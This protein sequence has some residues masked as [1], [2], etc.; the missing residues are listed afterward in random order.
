MVT[1]ACVVESGTRAK[2]YPFIFSILLVSCRM[3][4]GRRSPSSVVLQVAAPQRATICKTSQLGD[5]NW[6][7][8]HIRGWWQ[9]NDCLLRSYGMTATRHLLSKLFVLVIGDSTNQG[10]YDEICRGVLSGYRFEF[11]PHLCAQQ[12]VFQRRNR[13]MATSAKEV[14][15]SLQN[16]SSCRHHTVLVINFGAHEAKSLRTLCPDVLMNTTFKSVRLKG[17][18]TLTVWRASRDFFKARN[19]SMNRYLEQKCDAISMATSYVKALE[20]WVQNV[21][22]FGFTGRIIWRTIQINFGFD[23]HGCENTFKLKVNELTR[24]NA[25]FEALDVEVLDVE[26]LTGLRPETFNHARTNHFYCQCSSGCQCK[27]DTSCEAYQDECALV[28][29]PRCQ[30]QECEPLRQSL[31]DNGEPNRVAAQLLLNALDTNISWDWGKYKKSKPCFLTHPSTMLSRNFKDV[32]EKYILSLGLGSRSMRHRPPG[33]GQITDL[34]VAFVDPKQHL[35]DLRSDDER[36]VPVLTF[37]TAVTDASSPCAPLDTCVRNDSVVPHFS[38]PYGSISEASKDSNK[39]LDTLQEI[40]PF[41]A[42]IVE[43]P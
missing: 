4:D 39:L 15:R 24:T 20:A 34:Y 6:T 35:E 2:F 21:R 17:E 43:I 42:S 26:V 32:G 12:F 13:L 8:D 11:V 28:A 25:I 10:I 38:I 16:R 18:R 5:G 9:P 33:T 41:C 37:L 31:Y 19:R 22:R 14:A 3:I 27:R 1:R 29:R 36:D 30:T 40:L 23:F 7:F